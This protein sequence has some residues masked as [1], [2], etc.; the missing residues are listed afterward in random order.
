MEYHLDEN[1][2]KLPDESKKLI[3]IPLGMN[4]YTTTSTIGT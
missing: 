4:P 2:A 3:D 1:P